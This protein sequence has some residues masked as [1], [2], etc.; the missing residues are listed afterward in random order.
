MNPIYTY[1]ML[2]TLSLFNLLSEIMDYGTNITI[3]SVK[4]I[5]NAN[6]PDVWVFLDRNT[7]PWVVK[8]SNTNAYLNYYPDKKCFEGLYSSVYGSGSLKDFVTVE[9][10]DS[11]GNLIYNMSPFFSEISWKD[12]LPSLYEMT[13]VTCLSNNILFSNA[14]QESYTVNVM[15]SDAEIIDIPLRH[16]AAKDAFPGWNKMREH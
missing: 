2:N 13:L 7:T 14:R 8:H 12:V 3:R 4:A 15:T 11:S 9:L 10:H 16:K 6:T 1:I 5:V